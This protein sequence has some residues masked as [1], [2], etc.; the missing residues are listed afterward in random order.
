MNQIEVRSGSVYILI[1]S[2]LFEIL[3]VYNYYL[4]LL[5]LSWEK[6]NKY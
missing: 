1:T 6:K 4:K 5:L 3:L 2:Y